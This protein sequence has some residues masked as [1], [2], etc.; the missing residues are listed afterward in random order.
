MIR[1]QILELIFLNPR[2][3][4]QYS[5]YLHTS[6]LLL[7]DQSKKSG[8]YHKLVAWDD[9]YYALLCIGENNFYVRAY[10]ANNI[11]E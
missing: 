4:Q 8:R 10:Q 9:V 5:K 7:F 6:F 3:K 2:W 11:V 1:I